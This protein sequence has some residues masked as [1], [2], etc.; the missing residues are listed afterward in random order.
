MASP[1]YQRSAYHSKSVND[2]LQTAKAKTETNRKP[3]PRLVCLHDIP[4]VLRACMDTL[5]FHGI[6]AV[7]VEQIIPK[8]GEPIVVDIT[9]F[10]C[11]DRIEDAEWVRGA[12]GSTG[13]FDQFELR[14]SDMAVLRWNK[15]RIGYGPIRNAREQR[16]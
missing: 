5:R 14:I 16:V 8:P 12:M 1:Q 11:L 13:T 6:G 7:Q 4:S 15:P 10:R 9:Y 2:L 3:R